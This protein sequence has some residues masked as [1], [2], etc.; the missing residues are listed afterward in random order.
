MT[1]T[2]PLPDLLIPASS[3]KA[4]TALAVQLEPRS[5]PGQDSSRRGFGI[6]GS[7]RAGG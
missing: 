3:Q 7:K 1:T 2:N 6:W 5:S 4:V